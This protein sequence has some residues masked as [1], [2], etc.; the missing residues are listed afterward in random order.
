M[1]HVWSIIGQIVVSIGGV[2]VI[3]VFSWKKIIELLCNRLSQVYAHH[4]S[5][6]LENTNRNWING[7]MLAKN[8]LI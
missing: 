6:E 5:S 3:I 2:G 7:C 8:I 1:E 4:L